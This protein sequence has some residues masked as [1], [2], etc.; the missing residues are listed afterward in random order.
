MSKNPDKDINLVCP[1][2]YCFVNEKL[3]DKKH[4]VIVANRFL[5]K[6]PNGC[7]GNSIIENRQ[8]TKTKEYLAY[9]YTI[10]Q[11]CDEMEVQ[12][13]W[14]L[15]KEQQIDLEIEKKV[16][17]LNDLVELKLAMRFNGKPI[18]LKA[19]DLYDLSE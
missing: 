4:C 7:K 13:P 5:Y 17:E 16:G 2:C 18:K 11:Y 15:W 19:K 12:T 6:C 1:N 9:P 14:N 10:L 3:I 8:Y